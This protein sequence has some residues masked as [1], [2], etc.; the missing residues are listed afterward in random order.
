MSAASV[1]IFENSNLYDFTTGLDKYYG[2]DAKMLKNGLYGMYAGDANFDGKINSEDL[3]YYETDS[4][5]G[6]SGY[7]ITDFNIDG[8]VSAFDFN[9]LAPNKRNLVNTKIP[10]L[11]ASK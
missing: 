5:N 11:V 10:N 2:N 4:K 6:V 7:R 9:L 1:S 3:N 8:Y